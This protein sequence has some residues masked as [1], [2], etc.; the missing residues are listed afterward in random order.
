M[1]NATCLE[2]D[3]SIRSGG[4]QALRHTVANMAVTDL[5][6]VNEARGTA[7]RKMGEKLRRTGLHPE[8]HQRDGSSSEQGI[9][10]KREIVA[11][12]MH[13]AVL[14]MRLNKHDAMTRLVT[15]QH[16]VLS[17]MH[18]VRGVDAVPVV[19]AV[20]DRWLG[21]PVDEVKPKASTRLQRERNL[22]T[23]P[24]SVLLVEHWDRDDWTQ[25]WWA[26]AELRHQPNPGA[27]L[28][29]GL[30]D[31]LVTRYPPYRY[32][33]FAKVLVLRIGNVTGWAG[34]G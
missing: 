15:S 9:H 5:S 6:M 34:S 13:E 19:F 20:R 23:D 21:I 10:A 29:A 26:R 1:A 18:P 17:T 11:G 33:P 31:A 16:G 27:D 2:P 12:C 24:R 4:T 8:E 7:G 32:R 14:T 30:S 3:R 25:L 22:E 28:T